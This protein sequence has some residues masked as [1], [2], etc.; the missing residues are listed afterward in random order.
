MPRF[1]LSSLVR[2]LPA[3]RVTL[4]ALTMACGG[5][6]RSRRAE[7]VPPEPLPHAA[8]TILAAYGAIP[9]AAFLGG[10]RWLVVA[11]DHDAAV[12]AD[13]TSRTLTPVAASRPQ[14][15]VKPFSGFTVGDTAYVGDWAKGRLTIW[16]ADGALVGTVPGPPATR[17]IL[18]K[19]RDAAGQYYIEV[20]PVPGPDGSGNRDSIAIVRADP[21][22]TRFDTVARLTPIDVAEVQLVS[23]RRFER[24][25]MSGN[26]WWG[27]RPDGRLW[28]AR[29][30]PNRVNT[31]ARGRE[32]RGEPLPDPVLEVRRIDREAFIASF[33]EDVRNTLT[34]M[35]FAP[36]KPPFERGFAAPEGAVW[37]RK[38]RAYGDSIRRY[39]VV[40]T[41][42]TLSR[43]FTTVGDGVLIAAGRGTALMAEQY[44]GGVRL[45]EVR[46][47]APQ[48]PP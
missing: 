41:S 23:G 18:P 6:G 31:V 42:G 14:E 40:D 37:L 17:G 4:V 9:E 34:N 26:D 13:F 20:P 7:T 10:R 11:A 33:P 2:A 27:V 44:A 45:M 15:I 19:A 29:L 1:Q 32:V 47:P 21:G 8:D 46:L 3:A 30:G 12:V 35:P 43:V 48:A 39:Q 36:F 16:S 28:I 38:A 5:E 22:L 25:L 24:L